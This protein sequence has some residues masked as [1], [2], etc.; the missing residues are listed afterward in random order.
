[1]KKSKY[2]TS[3]KMKKIIIYWPSWYPFIGGITTHIHQ[4]IKCLPDYSFD[5]VANAVE[6]E[7][8]TEAFLSNATVK[9]VKPNDLTLYHRHKKLPKYYYPYIVFSD[10]LRIRRK[11]K[12]IRTSNHDVLHAHGPVVEPNSF[13]LDSKFHTTIFSSRA[14]FSKIKSKKVLTC[15]GLASHY[16]KN[17]EI[18]KIETK[19]LNAFDKIIC[20]DEYV[21]ENA[22]EI[23]QD[24]SK[25]EFIPNSID[26]D[27]FAYRNIEPREKLTLGYIGRLSVERGFS[28]VDELIKKKPDYLKL[29]LIVAGSEKKVKEI[30]DK[31]QNPD[32]T[33]LSNVMPSELPK[34]IWNMDIL[35]NPVSYEGSSRATLEAFSCGRPAIM[36][37]IGNRYPLI[38]GENGFLIKDDVQ[39]LLNVLD[40]INEDRSILN[41]MSNKAREIVE[42]EFSNEVIIPKIKRIYDSL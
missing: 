29:L 42:K 36:L 14:N 34:H 1:M 25:I 33:I 18:R 12:I 31:Y 40:N 37:D 32:I 26:V 7:L 23:V 4:I 11:L 30:K 22:K 19:L 15:H 9:R 41:M 17:P 35:L 6:N 27:N 3:E 5:I 28:L 24:Q 38:N 13:L 10:H 2:T 39:D 8:E 16:N 20:V 21:F